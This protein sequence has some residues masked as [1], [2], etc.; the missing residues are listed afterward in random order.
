MANEPVDYQANDRIGRGLRMWASEVPQIDAHGKDVVGRVLHLQ[1]VMITRINRNL[2]RFGLKYPSYA[3]LA[4]IRVSGPPYRLTPGDLLAKVVI[5]SGGLS[6][7]LAKL[8][9]GGL[10]SRSSDERD[11]RGVLVQ[12]TPAGFDLA[13]RAME[14][15]AAVER[16]LA[17]VIPR[18]AQ[19]ELAQLLS[20]LI[21]LNSAG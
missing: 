2:A 8:E 12:L 5:S 18:Q 10:V 3:I 6:N 20:Q 19:Q 7:L 21:A 11:G 16:E 13:T 15:H 4:T 1:E 9:R 17:D 14:A